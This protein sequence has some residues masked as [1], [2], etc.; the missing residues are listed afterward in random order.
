MKLYVSGP[1]SMMPGYNF[2]SFDTAAQVLDYL[3][4]DPISPADHDRELYPGIDETPECIAG[5]PL[6]DLSYANVLGWDFQQII[7]SDGIVLIP[8]WEA[9]RGAQY[10]LTVARACG[11]RVFHLV[12]N[13]GGGIGL[14]WVDGAD[15]ALIEPPKP[16]IIGLSGYAQTGKDTAALALGALGFTRLAFAD[17]LRE[18]LYQLNPTIKVKGNWTKL[19][20]HVQ[21][22]G[23]EQAKKLDGVRALLQRMGT[24]AV[25]MVIDENAWTN[26]VRARIDHAY[27]GFDTQPEPA[28]Y[29]IT[30]VRFPNEA[31]MIADMGGEVWRVHREGFAPV[32]AH[33]S[34]AALDDWPFDAHLTNDGQSIELYTNVVAETA[35]LRG[36]LDPAVSERL[37]AFFTDTPGDVDDCNSEVR[38]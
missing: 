13:G 34:E 25:R 21:T 7:D 16:V 36:V 2:A 26:V 27:D 10:E 6:S 23:W 4:H 9:S 32:N 1:M 37:A 30:D 12:T 22:V 11:K 24:E 28:R 5:T 8:G 29:V 35:W 15:F 18:S 38:A 14:P 20:T 3:G 33:A 31:K 17:A 19:Q